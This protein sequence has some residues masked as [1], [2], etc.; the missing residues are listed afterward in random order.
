MAKILVA[1]DEKS[2]RQ[3][4]D[5]VLQ[6]EGHD[7]KSAS[8]GTEALDLLQKLEFDVAFLDIKMPGME[9]I[10][11]L[12]K[13]RPTCPD[14]VFVI[15]S[16]HGTVQTAVEA[17]RQGA[18]EFIEKPLDR[19]R[20]L[21]VL[22]N[23]LAARRLSRENRNLKIAFQREVSILGETKAVKDLI[24]LVLKVAPT[25]ARVLITGENG[26]GKE[27]VARAVHTN[28]K[29]DKGAFVAVNCAALP[30][31]LIESELFGH[32]QGAFTGATQ[33][34]EGKFE[35]A[36]GGTL[37]LDEI[38]DMPLDAQAKLLRTLEDG[39]VIRIG[40]NAPIQ[41]NVRVLAATN[42]DIPALI[43]KG[44]FR[45]DLFFRLNVFP[46]HV[47]PLRHRKDDLAILATHFAQEFCKKNGV[48]AKT[49][50]PEAIELLK[51]HDW[52]G[53]VRELRNFVER[54]TIISNSEVI[55][56]AEMQGYLSTVGSATLSHDPRTYDEFREFTDR[57]YVEEHL[58]R[59][60][61]KIKPT[62]ED[63]GI[64]RNR[65]YALLKTLKMKEYVREQLAN[66]Q[67]EDEEEE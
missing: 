49:I 12:Q 20:L 23:A 55:E 8:S 63:M 58:R 13:A 67:E 30:A 54:I 62:A 9:G 2:I 25:E 52:P 61:F 11:V 28:S 37:F 48:A 57:L 39:T 59:N 1:D 32:E 17:T 47:P 38:G 66:L 15:I 4:M 16:A 65:M 45:E 41:V 42:Q 3:S 46:I 27:L 21:L 26:T 53:N 50:D 34:R 22:R 18:F 10:E 29:R 31:T 43:K 35:A 36:D 24:D 56:K 44:T 33:M 7:V 51:T 14:T 19:E 6:Y 5:T 40:S 64:S 60:R